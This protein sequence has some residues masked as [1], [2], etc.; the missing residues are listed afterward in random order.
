M[1]PWPRT[2]KQ[3]VPAGAAE[4]AELDWP[5]SSSLLP[6]GEAGGLFEGGGG[7]G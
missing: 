5:L 6:L 7:I 4:A 3:A 2:A 1:R